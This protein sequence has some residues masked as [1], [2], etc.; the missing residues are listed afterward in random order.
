M[1]A[2]PPPLRVHTLIDSLTWG[3][4]EML[5][6]DLAAG[7]CSSG[8]ELSVGYMIEVDGSPA[9]GPLRELGVEPE[10]VPVGRL[11]EVGAVPRLRRHLALVAP[12]VVHTHLGMADILGSLA[13]RSLSLPAVSTIH[14][15]ASQP[16]GRASSEGAR[17]RARQ[18]LAALA[19]RHACARV[20]AVSDAARDAYLATGWDRPD[21]VVT[22]HNGIARAAEPAEGARLRAELGIAPGELV[23]STVTVLRPGKGHELAIEA[24]RELLPRFPELRLLILGD[25]PSREEVE[26]LARPLGD[27]AILAGHRSDVMAALA[28]T[29]VLLHPTRMDAF[30]TALLEA[31]AAGVPVIAS[32]VGG[33]PEI[34]ADGRTGVLLAAPP[35]AAELTQHLALLLGDAALRAELG[36]RARERFMHEFTA[37]RW[38]ARLRLVYDDVLAGRG[39][40]ALS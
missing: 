23:L 25:G 9:A 27:A 38:V 16:T 3:G 33:I 36:A 11:L 1:P 13:A 19:R 40:R 20:I 18:R 21:H 17:G 35:T 4:A 28:A 6:A 5:L 22:V 14:L 2:A 26:R 7:A 12:D 24:V 34:V 37:E 31:A 29:D 39:P 32:A 10:L 30:P 15:V 8:I